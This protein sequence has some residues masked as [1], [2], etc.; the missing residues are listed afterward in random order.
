VADLADD[1]QPS[2]ALL[3]PRD[4]VVARPAV[5][6]DWHTGIRFGRNRRHPDLGLRVWAMGGAPQRD[7]AT[8][9]CLGRF[10]PTR[11]QCFAPLSARS[12]TAA[13]LAPSSVA[14]SKQGR[15]A[16]RVGTRTPGTSAA[17]LRPH[18]FWRSGGGSVPPAS[19]RCSSACEQVHAG[20][21]DVRGSVRRAATSAACCCSG[22]ALTTPPGHR[23]TSAALASLCTLRVFVGER[24]AVARGT[25]TRSAN[26]RVRQSSSARPSTR[27]ATASRVARPAEPSVHQGLLSRGR[28]ARRP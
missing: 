10:G 22:T 9:S 7:W 25:M 27:S 5:S 20:S 1:C 4:H 16:R 18:P 17:A 3:T 12:R 21:P 11:R 8:T 28:D 6:V 13:G 2:H 15:A 24:L 14:R 19:S 26:E 23:R